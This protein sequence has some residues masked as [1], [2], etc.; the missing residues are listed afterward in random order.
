MGEGGDVERG[1]DVCGADGERLDNCRRGGVERLRH[2][3]G[4]ALHKAP[5]EAEA[6]CCQELHGAFRGEG[7]RTH[8][9]FESFL[10][11]EGVH[12]C[13][14]LDIQLCD[15][16]KGHMNSGTFCTRNG[17]GHHGRGH[18]SDTVLGEGEG[19]TVDGK[20]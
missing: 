6:A 11:F 20:Q 1:S 13:G 10:H 15:L 7:V 17:C 9:V 5:A 12:A 2:C 14:I 3:E 16:L 4:G 8:L 18:M 19:S